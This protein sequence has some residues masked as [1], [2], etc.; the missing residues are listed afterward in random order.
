L[1]LKNDI[2]F[3]IIDYFRIFAANTNFKTLTA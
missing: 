1:L 3:F 2:S